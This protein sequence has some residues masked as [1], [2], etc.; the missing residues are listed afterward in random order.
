MINFGLKLVCRVNIGSS[1][2]KMLRYALYIAYVC[3]PTLVL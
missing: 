1:L 3:M 2:P